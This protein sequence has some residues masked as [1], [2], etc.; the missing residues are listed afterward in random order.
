[1]C[2]SVTIPPLRYYSPAIG[3]P[4]GS[5]QLHLSNHMSKV[6]CVDVNLEPA[7]HHPGLSFHDKLGARL[8]HF[9][10]A[11]PVYEDSQVLFDDLLYSIITIDL[12]KS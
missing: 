9:F 6:Y 3:I 5:C 11:K 8:Q 2:A 10:N 1:M 12:R 4:E 7:V